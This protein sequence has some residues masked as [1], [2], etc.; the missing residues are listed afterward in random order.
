MLKFLWLPIAL[1]AVPFAIYTAF[2]VLCSLKAIEA[3]GV[4]LPLGMKWIGY[5]WL[6]I[7]WPAD[8][9]F[10]QTW[11]RVIFGERREL[12]FS[13]HVQWRIDNGLATPKTLVWARFL[14]AGAPLHIK[15]VPPVE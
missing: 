15:R 9:L 2:L 11:G 5:V 7:G 14:N 10:N 8:V 6:L 13:A 3:Q 1:V 4:E 12:T